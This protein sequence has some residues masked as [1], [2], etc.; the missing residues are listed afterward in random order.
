MK[1]WILPLL[2]C[3]ASAFAED[4]D[5][6]AEPPSGAPHLE[7][8]DTIAPATEV[9]EAPKKAEPAAAKEEPKTPPK[10]SLLP[11]ESKAGVEGAAKKED[12]RV[13]PKPEPK[14][15]MKAVPAAKVPGADEE[16]AFAK[17]AAEDNDEKVQDA[18]MD[19]LAVFVR[20]HP[21]APQASEAMLLLAGLKQK[22]GDWELAAASL[23]RLLY[24]YPGTKIGLRAKSDFL[25][26]VD[27]KA[28][29][30]HRP[31]LNDL[32]KLPETSDKADRLSALWQKLADLAPDALYEPVAA[33]IRD[34]TV[35]FPDHK[36]G[37]KLQGSLA[38]L[39]AANGKPAAAMLSW[40]KLIALYPESPACPG[41][42]MA[43]GD[44]YADALRD[45]KKA[46]DAYQELVE[47]YPKANE[48]Q[49]ALENS[50]R[51]FDDK[52]RQYALA[53]EMHERI[54]KLFPKTPASLK[55]LKSI[56]KLQRDRLT[57]PEDAMKTLMR[58]SSMHGG[59]DGIDALLQAA[60]YARRDL[61]DNARQAEILRKVSDDYAGAKEA[62]Q[63]LYDAAG[64][65]EDTIKDN[66]KAIE[67]YREVASKFPSHK[68]ASRASDRA[69]KLEKAN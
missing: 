21:S 55:A 68:L 5:L 58:L 25:T 52:L 3:A 39:H 47:K 16:F 4:T 51:L 53:V 57:A 8:K 27:K 29:R 12:P 44:L 24:E 40:R 45:P 64:V 54:V 42:Q 67:L 22:K 7:H 65:Y 35:R 50:A 49:A 31:I 1:I 61:K 19:E 69:A 15:E 2:L 20:R 38:R 34:F 43:I 14:A 60:D 26:L 33:E 59:Q 62:P 30:K 18:A 56:A 6:I 41:A 46:I 10:P 11:E 13:E 66:A 63:A 9:Q 28:S 37:D 36:D 32:V 23:L 48:V 17:A